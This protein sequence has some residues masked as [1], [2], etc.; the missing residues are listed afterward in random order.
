MCVAGGRGVADRQGWSTSQLYLVQ[1]S[2]QRAGRWVLCILLLLLLARE[3]RAAPIRLWP[4]L[5]GRL[6]PVPAFHLIAAESGV[7]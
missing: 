2:H 3:H 1:P 6:K 4:K 7:V 5:P